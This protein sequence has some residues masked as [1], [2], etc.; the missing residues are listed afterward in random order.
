MER[1]AHRGSPRQQRQLLPSTAKQRVARIRIEREHKPARRLAAI[2][3]LDAP[4]TLRMRGWGELHRDI[5]SLAAL[6][7][8]FSVVSGLV[9]WW[10]RRPREHFAVPALALHDVRQVPSGIW[11][12][13]IALGFALPVFGISLAVLWMLESLRLCAAALRGPHHAH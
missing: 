4:H 2:E 3:V 13:G 8:I 6:A 5:R 7:A 10:L 11:L 1:N 9:M 12:C